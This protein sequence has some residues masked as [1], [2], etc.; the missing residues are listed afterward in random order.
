MVS[1]EI[2]ADKE[3]KIPYHVMAIS[4]PAKD[5]SAAAFQVEIGQC[6]VF[7]AFITTLLGFSL[8]GFLPVIVRTVF[9]QGPQTY[10][11]LLICSG[12]GSIVG[13]LVVAAS[14]RLKG[15]GYVALLTLMGLGVAISSFALS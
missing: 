11:L 1:S 4:G 7:L 15:Q 12:A 13:A 9:H 2:M 8:T 14:E 6:R 10:Q 5:Y 3:L